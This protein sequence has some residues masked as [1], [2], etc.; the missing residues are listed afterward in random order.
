MTDYPADSILVVLEAA[1]SG[2]LAT[3]AAGQKVA[4]IPTLVQKL[5]EEAKAL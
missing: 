2:E 5:V 3:S 4:D 1:P